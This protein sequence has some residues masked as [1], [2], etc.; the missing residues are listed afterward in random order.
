MAL[1]PNDD[2][3][4][5]PDSRALAATGRQRRPADAFHAVRPTFRTHAGRSDREDIV[6]DAGGLAKTRDDGA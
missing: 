6:T 3:S 2:K 5:G 4:P 1:A